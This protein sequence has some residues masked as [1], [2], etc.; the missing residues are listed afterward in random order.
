MSGKGLIVWGKDKGK[1]FMQIVYHLGA[2]FTDEDRLIRCL[3]A[4]RDVMAQEGVVVPDPKQYR[5]QLRDLAVKLKG[6]AAS[7]EQQAEILDPILGGQMAERV[8]FSWDSFMSLPPWVLKETLY[9][10]A[11]ERV[12]A[13]SQIFADYETEFFLAMRNP[14]T[15]LPL[16]H[17]VNK[18]VS[19]D[20]FLA[21]CDPYE[22]RWSYVIA[23]ILEL[24]PDVQLTVWC[25]EDTPLIWPEVLRNVAGL[26][27]DQPLVGEGEL[28]AMLMSGEGMSRMQAYMQTRPPGTV[29]QR[30]KIV[31]AFLDKFALPERMDLTIDL[32]EWT[33][34]LIDDLTAIYEEDMEKIAASGRVSFIQP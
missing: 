4:N 6:R 15:L 28:L 12:R 31:S 25:D 33:Q 20:A 3:S 14:A 17:R 19:Y 8:V 1:G 10:A 32:P 22:L 11:G 23:R 34:E 7:P 2:H 26:A 13:F 29:E 5:G 16:L 27:A 30:R 9:P 24:N 21:G 18:P